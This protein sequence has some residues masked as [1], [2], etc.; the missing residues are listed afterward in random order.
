MRLE[1]A[2]ILVVDDEAELRQIF[3]AW[4]GRKGCT[5]L[6]ASNGAEALSVLEAQKVDVLVSDI[7][8]PIMGG[9]ALVRTIYERELILPSIIFVS[10]FGDVDPRE[11]YGLGVEALM[12]KPLSRKDLIHALEESLR[13][14]EQL[15]LTPAAGP[16]DQ[17]VE[18]ALESVDEAAA[19]C[20]L[21]LG[22]GG[23][24]FASDRP[25]TEGK[26]IALSARFAGDG[27]TLEAQ[28]LVRWCDEE[29]LQAGVS[30]VYL[31][32]ACR[33]WVLA[34]ML[35]RACRSFVPQCRWGGVDAPSAAGAAGSVSP[36]DRVHQAVT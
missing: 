15:W 21:Q 2:T 20:R 35:D 23:C 31:D 10:G 8:M 7:R 6:T 33:E 18:L 27:R 16:I 32:P 13:E 28:G 25:L 29:T 36:Q 5:V 1:D 3:A 19:T 26:A 4:L 12:E 11:M 24:C 17:T 9:V 34:A 14:R 22:R 30:F